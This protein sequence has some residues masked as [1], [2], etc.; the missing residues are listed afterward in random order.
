M[1]AA[2]AAASAAAQEEVKSEDSSPTSAA[3]AAEGGGVSVTSRGRSLHNKPRSNVTGSLHG[4][5][6]PVLPSG[7]SRAALHQVLEA[8]QFVAFNNAGVGDR[9]SNVKACS[10]GA[11][12]SKSPKSNIDNNTSVSIVP[13]KVGGGRRSC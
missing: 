9:T 3:A 4:A 1:V 5:S 12:L 7:E 10:P 6:S 2:A 11:V 8:V 13:R